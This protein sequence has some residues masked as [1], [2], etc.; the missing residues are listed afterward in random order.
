MK[1]IIGLLLAALGGGIQGA[2]VYPLKFMKNWKWENGWFVFTITCCFIFP[3][4]LAFG[5]TPDLMDIYRQT[6]SITIWL[7]FISGIAWGIGVVLFGL[8]AE[9]LGMALGIAIITAL[10]AAFG[11]LFPLLFLPSDSFS[12]KALLFLIFGLLVLIIGVAQVAAAGKRRE[13][14]QKKEGQTSSSKRVSF[15]VGLV[16]CIVASIFCPAT[17]F[18]VFFGQPISESVKALGTV[19]PY[20][21]GYAQ[22]LPY[23]IGGFIVNTIYCI[24]LFIK[25]NSFKNY[26]NSGKTINMLLGVSMSGLFMVGMVLYTVALTIYIKDIGAVVGWPLFMAATI[27]AANFLGLMS[28]EWKGVSKRAVVK[29]FSGIILLIVAIVLVSL[30]N[31]FS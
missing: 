31:L 27:M 5:T 10:N 9:F 15:K 6:D 11:T 1:L 14:D 22:L 23:F 28:G 20:N 2:F 30:S 21:V 3:M 17:N 26:Y 19:A 13:L 7:V 8:G 29:L 4:V 25:N 12:T 24:Y 16:V 18:A